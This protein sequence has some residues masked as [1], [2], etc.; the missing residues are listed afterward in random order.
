MIGL[1]IRCVTLWLV[2]FELLAS[3][4]G[5]RGL[6]WLGA[7]VP[8]PLLLFPALA[9][10]PRGT[11]LLMRALGMTLAFLPALALQIVASGLRNRA[12]D[13]LRTLA[14][15]AL[16]DRTVERVDVPAAVGLVPALYV[17][18]SDGA[19]GAVCVLHGSGCE[20][21]YFAWRLTD[22]LLARGLAVLLVDLDGHGES[23]RPQRHPGATDV[24]AAAEGWLRAR[25]ARV[26][27]LGI[28]LGGCIAARAVADGV[29]AEAV[30]LLE[31]PP[32]LV[33]TNRDRLREA[34]WLIQPFMFTLFSEATGLQLGRAVVALVQAQTRPKIAAEISTWKLIRELD[35]LGSLPKIQAPLL[36]VYAGRDAI[37]TPAQAA[38]ARAVMPPGGRFELVPEASHLTLILHPGTV[39]MVAGWLREALNVDTLSVERC[40]L[41]RST[42]NAQRSTPSTVSPPKSGPQT[43]ILSPARRS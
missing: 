38:E 4:R 9:A 22:A 37:V 18:P 43:R 26:G 29:Q 3:W 23:L 1:G 10:H 32:R 11:S 14:P 13:P 31:T 21:T 30:A 24:V 16:A 35:L 15:G 5:W 33:F 12:L 20:K 7:R 28:S 39:G 6:S 17:T 34:R 27:L 19:K 2:L 8:R 36:L 25:H 40:D 41:E 42:L